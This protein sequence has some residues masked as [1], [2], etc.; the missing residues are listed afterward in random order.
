MLAY[1]IQRPWVE[2]PSARVGGVLSWL[3]FT[4]IMT[5]FR[6]PQKHLVY[7][8]KDL[9]WGKTHPEYGKQHTLCIWGPEWTKGKQDEW[10]STFIPLWTV[11][12]MWSAAS[13]AVCVS[14]FLNHEPKYS[15]SLSCHSRET[16]HHIWSR[17]SPKLS[18]KHVASR[19]L[20]LTMA[21]QELVR[22]QF[23]CPGIRLYNF[24][25]FIQQYPNS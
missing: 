1:H 5:T 24:C 7:F 17:G 3:I 18:T 6:M 25:A 11:K 2:F 9:T 16:R 23:F 21:R 14:P 10:T 20:K 15:S 22:T 4:V 19:G 12:S 8:Q 13:Q